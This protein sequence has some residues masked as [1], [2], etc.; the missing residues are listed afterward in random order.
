M[1]TKGERIFVINDN[2]HKK[3]EIYSMCRIKYIYRLNY[4]YIQW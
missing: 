2:N 3:N 4:Q 1:E